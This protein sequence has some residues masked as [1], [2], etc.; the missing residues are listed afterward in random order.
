MAK[1]KKRRKLTTSEALEE[2]LGRKAAKRL[3]QLANQLAEAGEV[4]VKKEKKKAK[5]N[6]KR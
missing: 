6:K 5:K 2:L 1:S 3:R 4:P